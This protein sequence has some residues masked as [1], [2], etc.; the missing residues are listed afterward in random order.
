VSVNAKALGQCQWYVNTVGD[1]W[2]F[3]YQLII[4]NWNQLPVSS[5]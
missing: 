1:R 5:S 3:L 2:R 4:I